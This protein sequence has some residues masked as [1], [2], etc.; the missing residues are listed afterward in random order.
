MS[1]NN[2]TAL[3]LI[4][5]TSNK[6]IHIDANDTTPPT[7]ADILKEL[8]SAQRELLGD[9]DYL[10]LNATGTVDGYSATTAEAT[11]SGATTGIWGNQT[12]HADG[13]FTL[14]T[15]STSNKTSYFAEK[16]TVGSMYLAQPKSAIISLAAAGLGIGAVTGDAVLLICS[17]NDGEPDIATP[18]YT[19][20]AINLSSVSTAFFTDYVFTFTSSTPL[21]VNTSYWIV[22]KYVS[23]EDNGDWLVVNFGDTAST[24]TK[25]RL[26]DA[27]TWTSFTTGRI[28][29]TLTYYQSDYIYTITL[30]YT[31]QKIFR[32]YAGSDLHAPTLN[33]LPFSETDFDILP[34]GIATDSFIVRYF[35]D[36]APV[37]YVHPSNAQVSYTYKYKKSVTAMSADTDIPLIPQD[38]RDILWKKAVLSLI[39]SGDGLQ[40]APFI[41]LYVNDIALLYRNMKRY[42]LPKTPGRIGVRNRQTIQNG[43][44][45]E[46]AEPNAWSSHEETGNDL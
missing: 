29:T 35:S 26:N 13:F 33:I 23:G 3:E 22:L 28:V 43:P 44:A 31:V 14:A 45:Y 12:N 4:N 20:N 34:S 27:T 21:V 32:L 39:A 8:N 17:D 25:T 36:G 11:L 46:R 6:V 24:T 40:D 15:D 42:W 30:P 5:R 38:Y 19:S 18:L 16:L 41:E 9:K 37:I 7:K 2:L 10:F 1:E